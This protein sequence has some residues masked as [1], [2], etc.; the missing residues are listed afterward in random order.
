MTLGG[1]VPLGLYYQ[2][3]YRFDSCVNPAT[4]VDQC[5]VPLHLV[6]LSL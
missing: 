5:Q 4:G 1:L 2:V 3:A 6:G